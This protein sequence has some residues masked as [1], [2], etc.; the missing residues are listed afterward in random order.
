MV[1][2]QAFASTL[3]KAMSEMNATHMLDVN[4]QQT[5][6]LI[7][8]A[9]IKYM[10]IVQTIEPVENSHGIATA[11]PGRHTPMQHLKSTH[12]AQNHEPM[13]TSQLFQSS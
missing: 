1:M 12:R 9:A 11:P 4:T 2:M 3:M 13:P 6:A 8:Q 7:S 10:Q 5:P